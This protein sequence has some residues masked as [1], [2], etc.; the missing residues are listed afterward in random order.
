[1][2]VSKVSHALMVVMVVAAQVEAVAAQLT[3][4][5]T[6]VVEAHHETQTPPSV[7][8]GIG[9]HV[10]C[11]GGSRSSLLLLLLLPLADAKGTNHRG[12]G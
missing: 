3:P 2:V 7:D 6:L 1:M 4:E 8:G 10:R 9:W 12:S 5:K 11:D